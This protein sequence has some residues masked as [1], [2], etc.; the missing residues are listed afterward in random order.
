VALM[1]MPRGSS[2][3]TAQK[4][5]EYLQGHQETTGRVETWHVDWMSLAWL[6][7]FAIALTVILLIWIW[8]YRTTRQRG[9]VYP[10][11]SFGGYTTELAGPASKFFLL[12]T[13]I[14]TAFATVLIAGHLIWGQKF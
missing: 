3:D 5:Y 1:E 6:W 7:G 10:I 9:G 13:L 4:Y 12:L 11:D 2:P 14:L 8:Q